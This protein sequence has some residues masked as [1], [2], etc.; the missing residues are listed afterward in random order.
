MTRGHDW[1]DVERLSLEE[2]LRLPLS[3]HLDCTYGP[4]DGTTVKRWRCRRCGFDMETNLPPE[5]Y[6]KA[7][8]SC[9]EEVVKQ[10]LET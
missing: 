10:V 7:P 9:D 3:C 5:S 8:P 6:K 2:K 1:E 4:V